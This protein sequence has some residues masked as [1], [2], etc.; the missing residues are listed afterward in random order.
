[1]NENNVLELHE[2]DDLKAA[3]NLMDERLDGQEIVSDEQLREVMMRK[4]TDIREN[5]KEGLIWGNLIFVPVIA[6]YAWANTRLTRD[7]ANIQIRSLKT[8]EERRLW[9][10]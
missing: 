2:L 5:L 7:F 6:W 1:M 3:Y 10:L 4:F 9:V 8:D